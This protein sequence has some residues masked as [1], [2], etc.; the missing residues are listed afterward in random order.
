MQKLVYILLFLLPAFT[1][2]GV[3]KGIPEDEAGGLSHQPSFSYPAEIPFAYIVKQNYSFQTL[4]ES[5]RFLFCYVL[6][7]QIVPKNFNYF[8]F[9]ELPYSKILYPR[10]AVYIKGHVLLN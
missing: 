1:S 2:L 3:E 8:V 7:G 10:V 6:P 4:S 9:I 5:Y